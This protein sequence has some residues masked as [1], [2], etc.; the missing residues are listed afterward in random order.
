MKDKQE[1]KKV[2]SYVYLIITWEILKVE[3]RI[4][5]NDGFRIQT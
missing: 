4:I 3:W 5:Q 2:Y 1:E